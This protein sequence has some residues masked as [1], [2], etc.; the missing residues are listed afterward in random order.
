MDL[1]D[2]FM[3]QTRNLWLNNFSSKRDGS[4]F[5]LQD[6]PSEEMAVM[7]SYKGLFSNGFIG[8]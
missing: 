8:S 4:I 5:K 7:V 6:T 3:G 2:E 1:K